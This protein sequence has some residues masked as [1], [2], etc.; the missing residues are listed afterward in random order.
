MT[1]KELRNLTG[2]PQG[3]FGEYF[4]IP[5]RTIQNWE[6]GQRQC[7]E[8]LLRLIEYKLKSEVLI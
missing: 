8:Y 5:L 4:G 7:P 6:G 3:A 1:T 2:M